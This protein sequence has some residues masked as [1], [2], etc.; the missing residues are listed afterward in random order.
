ML[1]RFELIGRV[2]KDTELSETS[3]GKPKAVIS[4]AVN[5]KDQTY[6]YT[7]ICYNKLAEICSEYVNKG[8]Q[9]Y[10]SG[11][12]KPRSYE[13]DGKTIYVTDFV[14]DKVE[15]LGGSNQQSKGLELPQDDSLPF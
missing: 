5:N 6:Y 12:F 3:N 14:A 7:I 9:V 4:L 11:E 8:N 1:A 15:F 10:L 2:T 13:K